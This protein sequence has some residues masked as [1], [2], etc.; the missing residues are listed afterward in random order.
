MKRMLVVSAVAGLVAASCGGSSDE[1]S[2]STAAPPVTTVAP[3]VTEAPTTQ[4]PTTAAPTTAAPSGPSAAT[5]LEEARGAV[6]RIVGTGTFADP[7][8]GVQANVP[9]SGT[10]FVVDPSGLAITNNH[11]VTGAALLEVYVEG[12]DKPRNARVIAVSECSDLAVI[13][14]DGAELP[15]L[16]WYDGAVSVGTKIYAAGFPLGASEYTVLDGI[17]SKEDAAGE[18]SWASVDAVIEHS[19]DT[20]PGNSGGPIITE[21]GKVIAVNY[22]GNELGQSFAI[23]IDV[24]RPVVDQ[25]IEGTDVNSIGINGEALNDGNVSG[26]WV[27]SIQSGSPADVAGVKAG[28]FVISMESVVLATDGTM[29]DYC[30][31]L[32]SHTAGDTLTIEVYRPETDQILE[33]QLNGRPLEVVTSFETEFDDE[34][35]DDGS[36]VGYSGY[37]TVSDNSGLISVSVPVEWSDVYGEVWTADIATGVVEEI[38]PALTAAPDLDAWYDT[39]GT[40][41]VFIGASAM[42]STGV[43]ETLDMLDFGDSCILEGRYEYDDGVYTGLYDFYTDC[44]AEGSLFFNVVAEPADQSWLASVQIIALTDADLA[45]ADEIFATFVVSPL[46]G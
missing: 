42:F 26:I 43:G 34:V 33:G 18:T 7:Y 23:G 20:L 25:L 14:I 5:S 31:I 46:A 12:E 28:D 3:P 41:G 10:G 17:V 32:R 9:G 27:S 2:A 13:D 8:S 6:V 21:D 29:S 30:D 11:V 16:D 19:A 22:A 45:A 4:A 1:S 38:G 37:T 24:A 15:Y 36:G 39:W 44:G 35:A 40:P